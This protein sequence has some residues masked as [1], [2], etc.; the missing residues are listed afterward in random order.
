M[1]LAGLDASRVI[2]FVLVLQQRTASAVGI[3]ADTIQTLGKWA[4]DSYKRYIRLS[5]QELCSISAALV[6]NTIN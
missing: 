5:R 3:S 1:S 6:T 4:S 2:P